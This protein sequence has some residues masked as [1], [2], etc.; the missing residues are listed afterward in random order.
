MKVLNTLAAYCAQHAP[1][2]LEFLEVL[3][4]TDSGSR[5]LEGL[6]AM[7]A[8][9][10]AR[11]RA[12]GFATQIHQS[13]AGP[14]LVA[15]RN[16]H[17]AAPTALL[18]GHTDT[19][20]DRGT[21]QQRPFAVRDGRAY[22]PGVADMKGG[23]T[24]MLGAVEALG[25]QGLLD[26]VNLVVVNNCDEEISSH[27]SRALI[28][29]AA[30]QAGAALVFEPGRPN[31]AIVTAR[32]GGQGYQ[33]SITGRAAHAGVN[34]QDGASA[35][36]ALARKV[37][38]LHALNDYDAGLS[39]NVG[40]VRGGSRANV[41]ADRA[42]AMVDVR[43]PTPELARR[44]KRDIEAIAAR[45]ELPGTQA[46]LQMDSQRDPMVF[47]EVTRPLLEAFSHVAK[48]LGFALQTTA[49]GGGSD[50]NFTAALGTPTLDALG[51]V[52]GGYHS[53]DEY[54][55]I[56]SL[57]QRAALAAGGLLCWARRHGRDA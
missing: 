18:V 43:V 51:P 8:Q 39:V 4:N 6:T 37:L 41:V 25:A 28:E 42:T 50:G 22:G 29:E 52:G 54:I 34:P 46:E 47:G 32:K 24:G 33:L 55:E 16:G 12:L 3:V 40:V 38:A 30:R 57:A 14:Q 44:V 2:W 21:A 26:E 20:F 23:L 31:G 48:E 11:W 5:D 45:V 36:E 1:T 17:Q 19:V 49:T 35:I 9:L 10:D 27:H 53:Q 13:E 15:R 7:S 56:D